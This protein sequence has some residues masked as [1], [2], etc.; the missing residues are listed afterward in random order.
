[1]LELC[2]AIS[3]EDVCHINVINDNVNVINVNV[4][5][6]NALRCFLPLDTFHFGRWCIS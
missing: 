2:K 1:M 5:N 3:P 6:D 4:I